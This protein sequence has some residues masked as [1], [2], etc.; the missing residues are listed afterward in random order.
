MRNRDVEEK[1]RQDLADEILATGIDRAS[2]EALARG[3]ALIRASGYGS[4]IITFQNGQI[5]MCDSTTK[6]KPERDS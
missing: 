5:I 6:I 4:L 2:L 1:T 3:L